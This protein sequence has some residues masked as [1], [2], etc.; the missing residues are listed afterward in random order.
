MA[1]MG[2]GFWGWTCNKLKTTASGLTESTVNLVLDNISYLKRGSKFSLKKDSDSV[3]TLENLELALD[4]TNE[5]LASLHLPLVATEASLGQ[6]GVKND[7]KHY[8]IVVS[9]LDLAL[10]LG[11]KTQSDPASE[12][13]L[14]QTQEQGSEI[15][16]D[17]K[18]DGDDY[19]QDY[20]DLSDELGSSRNSSGSLTT[21]LTESLTQFLRTLEARI[22]KINIIIRDPTTST[23][24]ELSL[25]MVRF[26]G[27]SSVSTQKQERVSTIRIGKIVLKSGSYVVF[28][29]EPGAEDAIKITQ[30][31]QSESDSN[32][33]DDSIVDEIFSLKRIKDINIDFSGSRVCAKIGIDQVHTMTDLVLAFVDS[34]ITSNEQEIQSSR[35]AQQIPA[36]GY[37]EVSKSFCCLQQSNENLH[38]SVF[39]QKIDFFNNINHKEIS[40]KSDF[41]VCFGEICVD[42]LSAPGTGRERKE[43]LRLD[44]KKLTF[45]MNSYCGLINAGIESLVGEIVTAD[46]K[47]LRVFEFAKESVPQN[48]ITVYLETDTNLSLFN[49]DSTEQKK[50]R[51]TKGYLVKVITTDQLNIN[52]EP[53]VF[54]VL[55]VNSILDFAPLA[56]KASAATVPE[57]TSSPDTKKDEKPA[58]PVRNSGI[59]LSLTLNSPHNKNSLNIKLN[60]PMKTVVPRTDTKGRD[61]TMGYMFVHNLINDYLCED[62]CVFDIYV[63]NLSFFS[64]AAKGK[65]ESS[66]M[67]IGFDNIS[68][69]LN[70]KGSERVVFTSTSKKRNAKQSYPIL[71]T[72]VKDNGKNVIEVNNSLN[73]KT[74]EAFDYLGPD[75]V[76]V[77]YLE[78]NTKDKTGTG[79]KKSVF[80]SDL[81][82]GRSCDEIDEEIKIANS[83]YDFNSIFKDP[84]LIYGN[85]PKEQ[86]KTLNW[87][88]YSSKCVTHAFICKHRH[89]DNTPF[90]FKNN[91]NVH[92]L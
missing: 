27:T 48:D 38:K 70:R 46:A 56:A 88:Y 37:E 64:V 25:E 61:S 72:S 74:Q 44:M 42:V 10:E 43:S 4:K 80:V 71:I 41:N 39:G 87:N 40:D 2:G 51:L 92:F 24:M 11:A 47:P 50:T 18:I 79:D 76:Y 85:I 66:T 52:L 86:A 77:K 55:F 5:T 91:I 73:T 6:I 23:S 14:Q 82:M 15:K 32:D 63:S 83:I 3:I 45:K 31:L 33:K 21:E 30:E 16:V 1:S 81:F 26:D 9:T 53:K 57:P 28:S 54:E 7:G 65:R 75:K 17:Q 62:L 12:Q 89:N 68:V 58:E 35:K 36:Y 19:Y 59:R 20:S 78:E 8:A 67:G 22:E 60:V 84:Y 90:F 13:Q 34:L 49:K 29:F 69:R